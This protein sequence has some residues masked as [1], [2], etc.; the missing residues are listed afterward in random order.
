MRY[1]GSS[2]FVKTLPTMRR[3][4]PADASA[5]ACAATR[6]TASLSGAIAGS[7]SSTAIAASRSCFSF[8]MASR[9]RSRSARIWRR[10][11]SVDEP[12]APPARRAA[13]AAAAPLAAPPP[14]RLDDDAFFLAASASSAARRAF[15]F[16]SSSALVPSVLPWPL[17]FCV[18]FCGCSVR[19]W[20]RR[21]C[22]RWERRVAAMGPS[23][24]HLISWGAK[25]RGEGLG[26]DPAR[27]LPN[28]ASYIFLLSISRVVDLLNLLHPVSSRRG[29]RRGWK[30]WRASRADSLATG[31]VR[32]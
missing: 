27:T 31:D 6:A 17:N 8:N 1:F 15:F 32:C 14:A 4:S 11:S 10:M 5:V 13:A 21:R 2:G 30:P 29:R 23:H 20:G 24:R 22:Q 7:S 28:T 9:R 3:R 26:R 19:S 16:S 12:P 25:S 18:E